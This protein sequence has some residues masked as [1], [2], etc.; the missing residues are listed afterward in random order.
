MAGR[1]AEFHYLRR[2][3]GSH[4]GRQSLFDL[5]RSGARSVQEELVFGWLLQYGEA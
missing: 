1:L 2:Q 3:E 5:D 4:P